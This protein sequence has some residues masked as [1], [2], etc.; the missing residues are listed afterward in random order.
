MLPTLPKLYVKVDS[1]V[2]VPP[3]TVKK[4][5]LLDRYAPAP[6][7]NLSAGPPLGGRVA[8]YV[9]TLVIAGFVPIFGK[10]LPYVVSS[11]AGEMHNQKY[12]FQHN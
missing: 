7:N 5:P 2:R 6:L 10:K 8:S 1:F 3:A 12:L 9:A 11:N 4:Y